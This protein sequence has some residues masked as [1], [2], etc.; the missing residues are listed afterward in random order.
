MQTVFSVM[1][2]FF[3]VMQCVTRLHYRACVMQLHELMR[4]C[5]T[6]ACLKF[7]MIVVVVVVVVVVV[8][9]E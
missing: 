1:Q 8:H 4:Y 2:T 6:H 3:S 9:A 7:A 5:M